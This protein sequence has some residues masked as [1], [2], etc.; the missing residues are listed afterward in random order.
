[1]SELEASAVPD[2]PPPDAR[3]LEGRLEDLPLCDILQVLQV[4]GKTGGLFLTHGDGRS[5]VVLFRNG[6]IVQVAG[7]ENHQ[8][9]GERLEQ[10]NVITRSQLDEASAYMASFPGMRLGDALV[11][12]GTL[13]RGHVEAEVRAMMADAV[14]TLMAWSVG[15]F[16]FRVGVLWPGPE[17]PD[18]P[19]DFL[20]EEG[21]E[22]QRII[23]DL[24]ER[25]AADDTAPLSRRPSKSAEEQAEEEV[26]ALLL[27]LNDNKQPAGA[28]PA[29]P[30]A[31]RAARKFLSLSE[32]LFSVQGRGEMGLVLLRY[33][34]ELYSDGALVHCQANGFKVLGQFGSPLVWGND[35]YSTGKTLFAKEELPVLEMVRTA[36]RPYAGLV[37]RTPEGALVPATKGTA[38]VVAALMIPMT[39]LGSVALVL[40]CR[41]A[42]AGAPDA[43]ALVALARQVALAFENLA[44]RDLAQRKGKTA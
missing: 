44:L 29:D 6:R 5:A 1:M 34:S 35:A 18:A 16:E 33:A 24:A 4:S 26:Q 39:V 38:G 31:F 14:Q 23:V 42:V 37:R 19:S 17:A 9:L 36:Q 41:T 12:K 7:A 25:Q 8:T 40:V 43:R 20:L 10:R 21:V 22:P 27:S 13:S 30:D 15:Q 3:A 11:E 32:E 2:T 28:D